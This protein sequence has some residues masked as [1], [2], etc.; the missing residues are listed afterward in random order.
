MHL[1][2]QHRAHSPMLLNK[3]HDKQVV[4]QYI[5]QVIPKLKFLVFS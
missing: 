3:V 5:D 4:F 1:S 2:A